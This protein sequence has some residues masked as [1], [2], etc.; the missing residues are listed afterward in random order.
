MGSNDLSKPVKIV[1]EV[2]FQKYCKIENIIKILKDFPTDWHEAVQYIV[3]K[4]SIFT[5][6]KL[7]KLKITD[8]LCLP[9]SIQIFFWKVLTKT[10]VCESVDLF[11]INTKIKILCKNYEFFKD[12]MDFLMPFWKYDFLDERYCD[13]NLKCLIFFESF[14]YMIKNID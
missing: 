7:L 12:L 8:L 5:F 10:W 2:I 1:F 11:I 3:E 9:Y 13:K 4:F 6:E 14:Y